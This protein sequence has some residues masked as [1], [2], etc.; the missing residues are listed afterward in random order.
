VHFEQFRAVR[1]EAAD[2]TQ[3]LEDRKVIERAKGVLMRRVKL[4]EQDAFRRGSGST[5]VPSRPPATS[6]SRP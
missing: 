6:P 4:D 2:L 3:P 5:S 1:R